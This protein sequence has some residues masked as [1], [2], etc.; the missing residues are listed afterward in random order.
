MNIPYWVFI[1]CSAIFAAYTMAYQKATLFWGKKIAADNELLP[2]GLQDAITPKWQ[3]IRNLVLFIL[4]L[5]SSVAG[6]III[7]WYMGLVGP[8][9][10][11]LLGGFISGAMRLKPDS[12]FF[13]DRI[14]KDLNRRLMTYR[15]RSDEQ[16]IVATEEVIKR[17][18]YVDSE[19]GGA[20]IVG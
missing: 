13:K 4:F 2:A 18:R 5:V 8:A 3:T 15:R 14:T 20:G 6:I 12:R 1:L 10:L 9:V 17:M 7:R 16:R 11:L 19:S